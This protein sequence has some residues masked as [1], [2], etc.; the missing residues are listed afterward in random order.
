MSSDEFLLDDKAF[1]LEL[2]PVGC[3]KKHACLQLFYEPKDNSFIAIKWNARCNQFTNGNILTV[4][5]N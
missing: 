5:T 3:Y 1:R 4:D 2:L